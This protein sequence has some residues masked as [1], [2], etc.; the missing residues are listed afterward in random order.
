M[1]VVV[2]VYGCCIISPMA[3]SCRYSQTLQGLSIAS[4]TVFCGLGAI[5]LLSLGLAGFAA[6]PLSVAAQRVLIVVYVRCD[7]H[8]LRL[9]SKNVPFPF[10][11]ASLTRG[12]LELWEKKCDFTVKQQFSHWKVT[13]SPHPMKETSLVRRR[14][15][16]HE[17]NGCCSP[18]SLF[19]RW[20]C[21]YERF[22]YIYIFC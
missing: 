18:S 14:D 19:D 8:C 11:F 6:M 10:F 22:I 7:V 16:V 12:L 2:C 15:H 17:K 13:W 4:C 3:S 5:V 1:N 9:D 20:V 21:N